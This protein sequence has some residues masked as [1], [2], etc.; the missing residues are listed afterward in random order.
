MAIGTTTAAA[1]ASAQSRREEREKA[2]KPTG[3]TDRQTDRQI[4]GISK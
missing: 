1:A 4:G 3:E 2:K